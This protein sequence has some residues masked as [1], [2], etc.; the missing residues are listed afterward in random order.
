MFKDNLI[1]LDKLYSILSQMKDK[2][3]IFADDIS[4]D[5]NDSSLSTMKAVLEGALIQCPKNA[6]IYATSN[7]RHL[8]RESF[9]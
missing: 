6:V 3:I 8:V 4:F 9:Q 7:R 5:E 1:N 2:F